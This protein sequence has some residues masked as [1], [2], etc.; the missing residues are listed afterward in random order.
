[1]PVP[2]VL[3][4]EKQHGELAG[5]EGGRPSQRD[6]R[7]LGD[8]GADLP[9]AVDLVVEQRDE[10]AGK[11]FAVGVER[12]AG[13]ADGHE[14]PA[15]ERGVRE[16][17]AVQQAMGEARGHEQ[18]GRAVE[19]TP[20]LIPAEHRRGDDEHRERRGQRAPVCA[21]RQG[22]LSA[23]GARWPILRGSSG[24]PRR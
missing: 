2:A 16:R 1:M 20:P 14:G 4:L 7:D 18:A 22:S 12:Q 23:T 5:G 17:R 13:A 3:A 8:S 11:E 19:E 10:V 9:D 24:P 21:E 15:Q 6:E